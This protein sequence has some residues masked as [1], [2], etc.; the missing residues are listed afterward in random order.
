VKPDSSTR[1]EPFVFDPVRLGTLAAQHRIAYSQATPFP[2]VV[3]DDLLPA[4]VLE[5]LVA[6]FPAP[7]Q[8]PWFGYESDRE[9]KLE[10]SNQQCM[11]P[12]TR[13]MLA[14]F[15]SGVFVDFLEELTG[16]SGLV[17]DPHLAGGGLHQIQPGGRLQIHADF[18]LH[19]RLLLQRRLNLLLYLN[20]EWQDDFGGHL[21]LWDRDMTRCQARI[22]PALGRCVVFTTTHESFHGH[23]DPLACPEGITRK[24]LALYYYSVPDDIPE[25]MEYH[26]TQFKRRPGDPLEFPDEGRTKEGKHSFGRLAPPVLVRMARTLKDPGG[27]RAFVADLLPPPVADS[28]RRYRRRP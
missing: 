18:N 6:D 7:D 25:G 28:L 27:R 4:E 8:A 20:R 19:P 23:P 12:F 2:H 24:S 26:G 5:D 16:I 22:S 13:H 15:N 1:A 17:V 21:E 14:Q 10:L 9:R 3:I 11:R